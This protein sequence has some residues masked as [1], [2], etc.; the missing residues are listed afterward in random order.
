[1]P[2]PRSGHRFSSR[3]RTCCAP[4]S[5][6]RGGCAR[7]NWPRNGRGRLL[8]RPS[9]T[10]RARWRPPVSRSTTPSRPRSPT[11]WCMRC[12]RGIS[13]SWRRAIRSMPRFRPGPG[14]CS[15]VP[16]PPTCGRYPGDLPITR[17][18]AS[19]KNYLVI[20]ADCHAGLPNE[21]YREWLDPEFRDTFDQQLAAR[22]AMEVELAERGL[23]NPEFAEEWEHENA[24]GLRGGWDA[25]RRDEELNADGVVGEVIFPDA[26]A[27][28][29]GGA[30]A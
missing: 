8:I 25:G 30:G 16:T 18:D 1:M 7:R 27:V 15:T 5:S 3:D 11:R 4:A 19:V 26:D 21:Q 24:E 12:G 9:R 2:G 14:P 10:S 17:G 29:G 13:G 6:A 20:S 23:R 22:A 28:T